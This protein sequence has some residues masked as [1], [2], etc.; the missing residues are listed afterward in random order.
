MVVTKELFHSL[1][2]IQPISRLKNTTIVSDWKKI[3][4]SKKAPELREYLLA[5]D[6]VM[7]RL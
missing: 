3:Y 5:R 1:N 6:D 2:G 7:A 4:R